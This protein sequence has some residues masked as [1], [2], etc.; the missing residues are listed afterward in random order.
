MKAIGLESYPVARIAYILCDSGES[1]LCVCV[2]EIV[3]VRERFTEA[4]RA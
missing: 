3:R 1:V 4:L 2:C